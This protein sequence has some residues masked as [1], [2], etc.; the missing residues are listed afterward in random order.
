MENEKLSEILRQKN[1]FVDGKK[2]NKK[3]IAAVVT[4]LLDKDIPATKY[5]DYWMWLGWE[6]CCIALEKEEKNA[7]T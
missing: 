3:A 6:K 1:P 5:H 4:F 2:T 7:K